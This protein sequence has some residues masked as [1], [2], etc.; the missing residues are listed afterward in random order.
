MR[1]YLLFYFFA[2]ANCAN[3]LFLSDIPSISHFMW[4]KI[5][6]DSLYERGHNITALSVHVEKS[7]ANFTFL[8]LDKVVPEV[9]KLNDKY[10]FFEFFKLGVSI[11]LSYFSKLL[12]IISKKSF[13]SQGYKQLQNYPENFKFDLV[14]YE[15]SLDSCLLGI[16]EK[17][18]NTSPLIGITPK[19]SSRPFG[20]NLLFPSFVPAHNLLVSSKMNFQQRLQSAISHLIEQI[21]IN[22]YIKPI[23]RQNIE[24]HH[25]NVNLDEIQRRTKIYLVNSDGFTSYPIPLF[26]SQINVGGMH[27]KKPKSLQNEFNAIADN[28]ING[29]IYFSLGTTLQNKLKREISLKILRTFGRLSS[30][31]FL[32]NFNQSKESLPMDLPEN[33]KNFNWVPQNDIL[34]HKN[35]KLFISHCDLLSIQEA[36][37]YAVPILSLPL[38]LI[39]F[40]DQPF[41]ANRIKQHGVSETLSI[42]DFTEDEFYETIKNMLENKTYKEN[43]K[44]VSKRFRDQPMTP[45][46]KAIYWIEW[47]MRN[48]DADLEGVAAD[49]KFF[50][51]YSFDVYGV[52]LTV[53]V[54]FCYSTL[55][56]VIFIIKT[57][58]YR[59]KNVKIF[60]KKSN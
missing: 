7:R 35:M 11:E 56:F 20:A 9:N 15:N 43:A 26:S 60:E 29:L 1:I 52:F 24:D 37:F 18:K 16:L 40:M 17:F 19:H 21:I 3:I 22:F 50:A 59:R 57:C 47:I 25:A 6:L 36:L 2:F 44:K 4:S 51:K 13:E 58:V 31:T 49:L 46:E 5:L 48:P 33:V 30:Y 34:S 23:T 28:A 55:K 53:F 39:L 27:I 54:S 45:I 41:Y 38:P 8:H 10:D 14:L 12:N 32:W 42:L